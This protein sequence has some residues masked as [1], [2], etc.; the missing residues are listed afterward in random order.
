M[1]EYQNNVMSSDAASENEDPSQQTS[2]VIQK[3]MNEWTSKIDALL[4]KDMTVNVEPA[5]KKAK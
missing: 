3:N 2:E 5:P 1:D 4:N